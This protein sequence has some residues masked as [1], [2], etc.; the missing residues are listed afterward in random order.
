MTGRWSIEQVEAVAPSAAAM[1]AARPLA[2][3]A[4]W[5]GLG[6]DERAVWGSF[7]GNSAEPYDTI[8]D[9]A[10]VGFSCSCPSR[11]IPCKH[12]LALLILWIGGHV[13]DAAPP[14]SVAAWMARRRPVPAKESSAVAP[15]ED[16]SAAA[17]PTA[18]DL[19][20]PGRDSGLDDGSGGE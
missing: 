4:R 20:A 10:T 17:G 5:H 11:R 3:T 1:S 6:A 13:V 12:T 15:S 14:A 7:H 2:T 16:D 9:H 19:P 8:V 18:D